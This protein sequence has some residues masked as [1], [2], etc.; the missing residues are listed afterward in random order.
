[1]PNLIPFTAAHQADAIAIW[2][3]AAHP[4]YPINE[5]F[6]AFNTT[7]CTGESIE[8]RLAMQKG[9]PDGF[10]LACAAK[11]NSL[12]WVS[13]IAV[14]PNFQRQ[15]LGSELLAWAEDWLKV[16]LCT[17]V[18][19]GGSLHPF[20]P[21]LPYVMSA[22]LPFFEKYGYS[23]P[24][25]QPCEYD[26]ARSLKDY[27][28]IYPKPDDATLLPMQPGEEPQLLEFLGREYPGRWEFEAKEFVKGGGRAAD[29]LLL[30]VDGD[31]HG[32]CRLTLADSERPIERFYPQRLPRPWGQFGPLG[33]SKA[34]RGRGLGGYL[35]DGAAVHLQSLG[36][37]GCVIDWTSLVDLYGK[38]GFTEYNR[39]VTLFKDLKS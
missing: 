9:E 20:A 36:V 21:G 33:L 25:H 14:H 17:R 2:N 34:M 3:A 5:R 8:G 16:R 30:R 32:F 15:G 1:M 35:I 4:D 18:R 37:D 11:D 7:P 38:F 24:A 27:R 6:L 28:S 12:G 23:S 19:I 13:A 29:Y 10:V 31:V 39:Y 26:I 22:S